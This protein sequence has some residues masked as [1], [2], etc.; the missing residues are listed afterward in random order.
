MPT[1]STTPTPTIKAEPRTRKPLRRARRAQRERLV[2]VERVG[3]HDRLPAVVDARPRV[4]RARARR[5]RVRVA[6]V[7]PQAVPALRAG[8]V[9]REVLQVVGRA[10]E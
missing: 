9:A 4:R 1:S 2:D 3:V 5:E 8:G 7:L 10:D 6:R